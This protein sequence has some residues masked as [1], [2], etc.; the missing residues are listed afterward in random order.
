V[1]GHFFFVYIHP[2]MDGN[3]RMG[4]F[5]MNVMLAAGSYPWIIVPVEQRNK[6]M[7]TLEEASIRQ[8]ILPFS[9]FLADLMETR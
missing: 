3:G 8:N 5:L 7:A 6:Y 1:L 4:R 2:Y 9:N